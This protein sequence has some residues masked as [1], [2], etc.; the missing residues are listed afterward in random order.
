MIPILVGVSLIIIP[1]LVCI[2]G[3]RRYRVSAED[4]FPP[5][6]D[7]EFLARC[8]PGTSPEVA[9]KVRRMVADKLGVPYE[10][11]YPSSRFLEDL[12]SD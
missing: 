2:A 8:T 6:S 3:A 10:R 11:I 1:L 4:Y 5:I 9:L 12:G 7:A